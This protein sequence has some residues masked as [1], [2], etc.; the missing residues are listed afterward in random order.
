[1]YFAKGS[2]AKEGGFL[3][4]LAGRAYPLS[5]VSVFGGV[6]LAEL[7]TWPW[8]MYGVW[9]GIAAFLV[10][11]WVQFGRPLRRHIRLKHPCEVHFQIRSKDNRLQ[12][13]ARQDGLG[14]RVKELVLPSF[15]EVEIEIGCK[16]KLPFNEKEQ[17]FACDGERDKKPCPVEWVVHFVET[18]K[19]GG[20]PGTDEGHYIDVHK[21]Y[22]RVTGTARN[23]GTHFVTGF[24]LLTKNPGRYKARLFFLTDEREG[25]ADLSI[26]V[27]DD[28]QTCM[29]CDEHWECGIS[30]TPRACTSAFP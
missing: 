25:V 2:A 12:P 9:V 27:E 15:S 21:G 18:G 28:P 7:A 5:V 17:I 3:C 19:K 4:A 11:L 6:M 13:Y 30:P 20:M 23:T 29:V 16:A 24:K 22:H 8:Q 26:L 1:M 14:H 10:L